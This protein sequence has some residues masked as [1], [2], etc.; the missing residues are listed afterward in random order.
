[1]CK[2][3]LV[4]TT[5]PPSR[6]DG[7]TARRDRNR[8]SVMD[9][10]IELFTE[11]R[12]PPSAP[13]VAER[14][15]VSLRSVY[16]YFDDHDDLIT[17]AMARHVERNEPLFELDTTTSAPLTARVERLLDARLA[18]YAAVADTMRVAI[19]RSGD[20]PGIAEQLATRRGQL[21]QQTAELFAP[22]LAAT[23]APTAQ[24]VLGA[25]D[26]LTQFEAPE[27]LRT[28]GNMSMD[29]VRSTLVIAVLRLL[30]A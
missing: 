22:E 21:R 12:I 11:G 5:P 30:S 2:G 4:T 18:L 26:A 10:V 16:R 6:V 15:G 8:D 14:S 7:R 17:T 27:H 24:A 25:V 9:A 28:I 23:D 29:E 13:E 20:I 19:I 3:C 1:M